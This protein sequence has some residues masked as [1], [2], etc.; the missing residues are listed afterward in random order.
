MSTFSSSGDPRD[1]AVS[2]A[3]TEASVTTDSST[4]HSFLSTA[5]IAWLQ[6]DQQQHA[7]AVMMA[8]QVLMSHGRPLLTSARLLGPALNGTLFDL[9]ADRV[10]SP[11]IVHGARHML[12][13][14]RLVELG[15]RIRVA[16]VNNSLPF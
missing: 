10:L 12:Q 15:T 4:S 5:A 9:V 7:A 6:R 8:A 16:D 14:A 11:T 13:A 3:Q 2:S 1:D